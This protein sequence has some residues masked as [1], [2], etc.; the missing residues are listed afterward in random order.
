MSI[1]KTTQTNTTAMMYDRLLAFAESLETYVA[2][3]AELSAKIESDIDR[4]E[5]LIE[6]R[7]HDDKQ[8]GN[9]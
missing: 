7:K 1:P 6:R 3:C 4:L 9:R 8:P 5:R 2:Q